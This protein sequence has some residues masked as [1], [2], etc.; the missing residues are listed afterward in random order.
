[1]RV[2]QSLLS[3][4]CSMAWAMALTRA[5]AESAPPRTAA[6][7]MSPPSALLPAASAM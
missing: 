6:S 5:R 1:M 2:R 3:L 4:L 7:R